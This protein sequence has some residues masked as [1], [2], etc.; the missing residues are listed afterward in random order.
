MSPSDNC[1]LSLRIHPDLWARVFVAHST[2]NEN[3]RCKAEMKTLFASSKFLRRLG[4]CT[5]GQWRSSVIQSAVVWLLKINQNGSG[6]RGMRTRTGL[7]IVSKLTRYSFLDV[8]WVICCMRRIFV[9]VY[10]V[11]VSFMSIS[12]R[13][14]ITVITVRKGGFTQTALESYQ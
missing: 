12:V 13:L 8:Q 5:F 3:R 11:S 9:C 4:R 10:L 14:I 2:A 1:Y 7:P 6:F